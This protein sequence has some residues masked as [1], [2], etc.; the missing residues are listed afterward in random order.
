LL[1]GVG[2]PCNAEEIYTE[3]KERR[4]REWINVRE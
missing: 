4:E 2:K 3:R 1:V